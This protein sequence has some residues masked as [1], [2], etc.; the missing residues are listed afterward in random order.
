MTG[1]I[2]GKE[3]NGGAVMVP[4]GANTDDWIS[5]VANYVRNAFGNAGRPYITPDQVAAARKSTHAQG[6]VDVRRARAD[7]AGAAREPRTSGR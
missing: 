7:R 2:E 5:D 1:P 3:F 4:M 6:A